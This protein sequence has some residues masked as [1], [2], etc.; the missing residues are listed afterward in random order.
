MLTIHARPG[1]ELS[2][3]QGVEL[4]IWAETDGDGGIADEERKQGKEEGR[5][6]ERARREAEV[7]CFKQVSRR[8]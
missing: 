1:N 8:P 6:K 5:E 7:A 4:G 2:A 3:G